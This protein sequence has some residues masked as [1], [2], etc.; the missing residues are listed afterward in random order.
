[1]N[2]LEFDFKG[3]LHLNSSTPNSPQPS[4][5]HQTADRAGRQQLPRHAAEDPLAKAAVSIGARD[6]QSAHSPL[7]RTGAL[8]LEHD[9]G[10]VLYAV[11]RQVSSDIVEPSECGLLIARPTRFDDADARRPLQP[12]RPARRDELP[13]YPSSRSRHILPAVGPLLRARPMSDG[14]F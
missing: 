13:E 4:V 3:R 8:L 1:M 7:F 2:T 10:P 11:V 9:L 12:V 5:R 14:P 6:Q